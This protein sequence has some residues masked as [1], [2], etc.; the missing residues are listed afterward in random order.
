MNLPRADLA[1]PPH[2]ANPRQLSL[3]VVNGRRDFEAT[4]LAVLEFL[5]PSQPSAKALFQVELVLE[6]SLMNIVWHA[7]DDDQ[8]HPIALHL[9]DTGDAVE[10]RFEDD[11]K[12]FD[13]TAARAPV[14]PSSLDEATPGG[15]GLVLVRKF[16]RSIAYTRTAGRNCLAIEVALH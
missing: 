14:L 12:P 10:M 9:A 15:L 1:P 4:R 16:A 11:G 13:P 6:E 8:T 5:A 7:F 3:S 2:T